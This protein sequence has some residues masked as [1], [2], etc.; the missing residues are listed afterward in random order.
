M[1][2]TASLPAYLLPGVPVCQP[3][4]LDGDPSFATEILPGPPP[5]AS[6]QQTIVKRDPKKPATVFSYLPATDPGT[7]YSGLMHGTLSA[8]DT[9][10]PRKRARVDKGL[11]TGRAQRASARSQNATSS[12]VPDPALNDGASSSQPPPTSADTDVQSITEL[13]PPL[14]RSNSIQSITMDPKPGS[15]RPRRK[16]KGKAKEIEPVVRIKEEPKPVS[17]L[18]PEPA[19]NLLNNNDHCSSCRSQGALVYCDGCPRAFHLWCLDPPME[20]IDEGD[21]SWFC[22]ACT[23]TKNPP[24]KPPHSL[25]AP[26]IHLVETSI[27]TEY[28]LP[29]D[30]RNFFKDVTTGPRG[31]YV[32][33]SEIKQPRLN[34]H[35]QPED[36][37]AHR[38]R[39][40]NGQ[41]VLCF[42]CGTSALPENVAATAPAAKRARRATAKAMQYEV[43]KDI[44]SCDYCNLHWHL[45]CLDPPLSTMPTFTKKW[46]CP[47]HAER[48]LAPKKRIPKQN[49]TP[50]D[51]TK[52]SQWN[53]G[54][55]EILESDITPAADAQKVAVDEVLI[56]GRRYRIP[57][58][59][60]LLDFWNKISKKSKDGEEASGLAWSPLTSLSSLDDEDTSPVTS[61]AHNPHDFQVA[62]WLFD[63][64]KGKPSSSFRAPAAPGPK[65]VAN[66]AVKRELANEAPLETEN[67]S[68]SRPARVSR[69][70]STQK[71]NPKSTVNGAQMTSEVAVT[72][73]PSATS[74]TT[75]GISTRR[76]RSTNHL[77]PEASTR[78]LRSRSRNADATK[79]RRAAEEELVS[80]PPLATASAPAPSRSRVRVKLE[81]T[82]SNLSLLNG[83]SIEPATAPAPAK[84]AKRARAA[85]KKDP[86][87]NA[88]DEN[89]EKKSRK[90]KE[91]EDDNQRAEKAKEK[92]EKAK[93]APRLPTSTASLSSLSTVTMT[94][95]ATT[96]IPTPVTPS[97]KI[98]IPR[99]ALNGSPAVTTAPKAT[100]STSTRPS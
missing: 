62:Q 98:R 38:L 11:A 21:S 27:P 43:W 3:S 50:V 12:S 52:P 72:A 39:D 45:D 69:T 51:I 19:S 40:R 73:T 33:T 46:M 59:V 24:R 79:T 61:G 22:P 66:G 57:E 81:E 80:T 5:V 18:T 20:S 23:I 28:Q 71:R 54:N 99:L 74:T 25:L 17:L 49:A 91:R 89:P 76:K 68:T 48:I 42:R 85:K 7:T 34:R 83:L 8:Q 65:A 77:Q 26:L 1:S 94:P 95:A 100:T 10:G 93:A 14:S 84:P 64:Q 82:D 31:A 4:Y 32:D 47:N 29:D 30:I 37:E 78:E 9:N 70:A 87:E 6:I 36:R 60:V 92:K 86:E 58:R 53:N 67:A 15:S 75:T 97:L 16:D 55:V 41:P 90:R 35:G 56:N 13:P 88:K 44:I 96:T 63:F 2:S